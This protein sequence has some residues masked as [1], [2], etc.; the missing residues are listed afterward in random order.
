MLLV[1][2]MDDFLKPVQD[3]ADEALSQI[4]YMVN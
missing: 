1:L 2:S 4:T 3:E